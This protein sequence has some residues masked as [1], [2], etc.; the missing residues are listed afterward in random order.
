MSQED[1]AQDEEIFQWTL[2]NGPRTPTP[3]FKPSDKGYGPEKC[4]NED[5]EAPLPEARRRAG[6]RLCTDCQTAAEVAEKRRY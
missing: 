6:R 4:T 3:E 1:R 5:C 2:L